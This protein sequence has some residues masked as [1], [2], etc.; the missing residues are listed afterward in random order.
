[1]ATEQNDQGSAL[2][3]AVTERDDQE[4]APLHDNPDTPYVSRMNVHFMERD[5]H[6]GSSVRVNPRPYNGTSSWRSYMSHFERV[7][8]IN[9]WNEE[10]KIDFLWVNLT[11]S[12]LTYVET[13]AEDRTCS[14]SDLCEALDERFGD[15]QLAEVFKSELRSR[16][17]REGESLPAL[18][19]EIYSLVQRAYPEIGREGVE[20]LAIEKFREA[21]PDHEQRMAVFRSKARMID[22]A[23]KAAIDAE[24][25]QISE[26]R[27]APLPKIRAVVD[28]EVEQHSRDEERGSMRAVSARQGDH[29]EIMKKLEEL[30]AKIKTEGP[31]PPHPAYKRS[32]PRCYYCDKLGHLVR[33]CRK[34]LADAK[35]ETQEGNEQQQH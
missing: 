30:I 7:S 32:S 34:K 2:P 3:H 18:A 23:V 13:L 17:R 5:R 15:S 4:S 21:L 12:A 1:M 9:R 8:R 20:E 19:Q 29:Q 35:R 10:Q 6:S 14:Y 26:S 33:D 16:R 31:M 11:G 27:R 28:Q 25:W 24:S 22:Q